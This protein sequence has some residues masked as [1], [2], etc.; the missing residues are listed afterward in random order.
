MAYI[1]R[2]KS[3]QNYFFSNKVG[4]TE[5]LQATVFSEH[6]K[7]KLHLPLDG[8]W[9]RVAKKDDSR[10][11]STHPDYGLPDEVRLQ[12][13]YLSLQI[14]V[15]AAAQRMKVSPSSIYNWRKQ[16]MENHNA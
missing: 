16:I 4:W 12:C 8:Q 5:M 7:H 11:F 3:N 14:G 10:L 15:K 6:E 1:I 13:L 2:S 9:V